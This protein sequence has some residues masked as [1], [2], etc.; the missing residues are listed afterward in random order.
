MSTARGGW[1]GDDRPTPGRLGRTANE[2]DLASEPRVDVAPDGVGAHLTGEVH[3]DGGGIGSSDVVDAVCDSINLPG[4]T[5]TVT[6]KEVDTSGAAIND[7]ASPDRGDYGEVTITATISSL[8]NAPIISSF[9]PAQL[10][11]D[12]T[13]RLEQDAA[14]TAG[15]SGNC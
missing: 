6:M 12:A 5:V 8:S 11:N 13:F 2:V 7:G 15:A 1:D 3:L 4:S 10:S 9:L 14:W